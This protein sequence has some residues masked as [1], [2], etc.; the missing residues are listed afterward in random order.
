LTHVARSLAVGILLTCLPSFAQA[1]VASELIATGFVSPIAFVVDP[2]DHSTFYVVEQRGTIRIVRNKTVSATLFLD[3]RSGIASGG[4]RGLLGFAFPPDAATSRRCYVNF[5]NTDGH[6]VIARFTRTLEGAIDPTSRFD[7]VWPDGR[8]FIEQPFANHNG[9]HLAFGPDGYLYIGLGD[10]GGGGDPLNTA[11]NPNTL[12]GKMLRIDVN[13]PDHDPRGYRVPDDNP[14]VDRQPIA[15]LTEIWAFGLRNPWRYNFDDVRLGGTGALIVGDVGQGALEEVNWEPAGRGG[16]NY[17]WRLREGRQDYLPNTPAAYLPLTE[18]IHDYPR[19]DGSSITGGFVYRGAALHPIFSGRYFFADFVAGRVYTLGIALD[20]QGEARLVDV[21]ELTDQLGGANELG[22]ISSFGVDAAGELYLVSYSRGRILKIVNAGPILV[23]DRTSLKFSAV[24]GAAPPPAQSVTLNQSGSGTVS[25]TAMSN[26]LWLLVSPSSGTGTGALTIALNASDPV[27]QAVGSS[28]GR[29]TVLGTNTVTIDVTL[30]VS[31]PGSTSPP[32]GQID[33]P[34]QNASSVVGAIGVT[35]WALDDIAVSRVQIYRNCLP[36]DVAACQSINGVNVVYIGDAAFVPGARAGVEAQFPNYPQAYRAG[37]G[38]LLLT[39]MLPNVSAGVGYGGQGSLTIYALATD[40]EGNRRF[41]G[42]AWTGAESSTPTFLTMANATIAK[43]FGALDTPAQ[44]QTVSGTL[45]N[46]GWVLTPDS[47]TSADSGDIIIPTNGSTMVVVI[48]GAGAGNV[49]YDQCRG[50]VGNPVPAGV[51]CNDDV[52]NIFGN[53]APQP[54]FTTR[55]SNPTLFRNLDASRAAI[56][57]FDIDT[58]VLT[59]GRHSIA[60]GVT[61]SA[62]RAEGIGSRDFIVLNGSSLMAGQSAAVADGAAEIVGR[63]ADIASHPTSD[64]KVWGRTGF[65]FD[66]SLEEVAPNSTGV[67]HVRLPELGRLELWLDDTITAGFHN[68]NGELRP[69]PSGSHLDTSTGRFTW[70]PL[71]GYIGPYELVFLDGDTKIPVIVKIVQKTQPTS[72]V[73][74]GYIDAPTVNRVVSRG[75]SVAGWAMD[76]GA[77]Q[78]SGVGAVHVWAR[79]VDQPAA[80][81]V[82]LGA[83]DLGVER[84]DVAAAFSV[85]ADRTGWNLTT[86]AELEAGTYELTAYFWSNRTAR[87]ED[88][89]TINIMVR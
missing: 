66:R 14:F 29:I 77:W 9:G 73:M 10:G 21:L 5:T 26:A 68:A 22:N 69:L 44:G 49:T 30:T 71:V 47:N 2:V 80:L 27:L 64:G 88:A 11:Q 63:A 70:G 41:L 87:F 72:G 56:G 46:F 61:D 79:R 82:F 38:Y 19:T 62:G 83:A 74:R 55:T 45:A 24:S 13:V 8:R 28:S 50:S 1:Q 33:T 25:W 57:S 48:D 36:F 60:W 15:A 16:R 81:S 52:A 18:P 85:K 31:S 84:P 35:G 40:V 51:Y 67:R 7:L 39:N 65:D 3:L 59:N 43:P 86:T 54:T 37:W 53:P 4:E 75:F 58:T 89:R 20:G 32:F 78:G 17:G 6:T 76:L 23:A 34:V 12:L 42:R